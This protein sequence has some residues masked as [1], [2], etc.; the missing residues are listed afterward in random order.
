MARIRRMRASTKRRRCAPERRTH[1]YGAC[2]FGA[3]A[4]RA[5]RCTAHGA[6]TIE[7]RTHFGGD[8]YLVMSL[9]MAVLAQIDGLA[10]IVVEPE[11]R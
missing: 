8:D 9:A 10:S 3:T 5:R 1:N 6:Q 11:G 4:R 2:C 7:R